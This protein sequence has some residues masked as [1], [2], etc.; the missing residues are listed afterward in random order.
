M[1][2]DFGQYGPQIV[3][4]RRFYP[5]NVEYWENIKDYDE[6]T[7]QYTMAEK[8]DKLT[9][10]EAIVLFRK[11]NPTGFAAIYRIIHWHWPEQRA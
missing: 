2:K 9:M 4:I 1:E 3:Q 5:D 11:L 8:E 10:N 6:E 7:K